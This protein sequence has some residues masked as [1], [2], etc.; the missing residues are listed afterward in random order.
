MS[1]RRKAQPKLPENE[2]QAVDALVELIAS[3]IAN[4]LKP[5]VEKRLRLFG[6]EF[7]RYLKEN[8]NAS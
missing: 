6:A 1:R 7:K 2:E 8:E 4:I 3:D 5:V